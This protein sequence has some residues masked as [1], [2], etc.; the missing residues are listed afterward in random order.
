LVRWGWQGEGAFLDAIELCVDRED[1]Q[2]FRLLTIDTTP[3]YV[4]TTPIPAT[5]ARWSYKAIYRVGDARVGQWSAVST[6]A[7]G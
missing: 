4:D 2:G 6:I 3:S 1:G 5:A 7:V